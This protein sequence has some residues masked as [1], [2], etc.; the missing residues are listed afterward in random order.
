[1]KKTNFYKYFA[2]FFVAATLSVIAACGSK[3][4]S[5]QQPTVLPPQVVYPNCVNCQGING[6]ILFSGESADYTGSLRIT[7]AFSGQNMTV[8]PYPYNTMG[9]TTETYN[10]MVS[11]SGQMIL[12]Q[13]INLGYCVIPAGTYSVVTSQAGQWSYAIVSNLA[14]QAVGP[15]SVMLNFNG[16]VSASSYL[17]N[18]QLSTISASKGRMYGNLQVQSVNGQACYQMIGVQ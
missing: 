5:N 14:M 7:W 13:N 12:N 4:G 15:A 9:V 17:S 3:G 1:M 18:G 10:G 11:T 8:Q 2:G 6:A 16:Q